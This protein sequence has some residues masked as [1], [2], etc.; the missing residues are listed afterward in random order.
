MSG[1][2]T[3]FYTSYLF[4]DNDAPRYFMGGSALS[5]A[6]LLCAL[7]ALG[8]RFYLQRLNRKIELHGGNVEAALHASSGHMDTYK[9]YKYGL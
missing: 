3:Q 4:P 7:S 9:T 8:L 6:V 5:V 1:G 2:A